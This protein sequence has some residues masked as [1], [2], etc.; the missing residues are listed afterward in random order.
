MKYLYPYECEK[1]NLS[2]PSELQA[3]ID[4]NRREGRRSSYGQFD[5][6]MQGQM[7][8]MNQM[9]R[10]PLPGGMQQMSPLSLVTHG[11]TAAHHRIMGG[12]PNQ[13]SSLVPHE[14]EQRMMEYL[15]LFQ[16][17]KEP[18]RSQSPEVSPKDALSALEASRLAIWSMYKNNTSP[19]TSIN[20]SPPGNEPQRYVFYRNFLKDKNLKFSIFLTVKH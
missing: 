19:P 12:M 14:I 2:S 8:G 10:S 1:K 7:G 6:G 17:P 4:G 11:Q 5:S 20:T 13:M 18:R 3:A 9:Q 16:Q 15:K